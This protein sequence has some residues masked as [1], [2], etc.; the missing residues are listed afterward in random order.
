MS[1]PVQ[2]IITVNFTEH[3]WVASGI[4][5]SNEFDL[6]LESPFSLENYSTAIF[7]KLFNI[8]LSQIADLLDYH[9]LQLSAPVKWLNNLEKLIKLNAVHFTS[10]ELHHRHTKL[11][12]EIDHK[13]QSFQA[14][15]LG[16]HRRDLLLKN[17]NGFS[18]KKAYCFTAVKNQLTDLATHEE[19]IELLQD[20]IFEYRQDSPDFVSLKE[21]P[22]DVL[23]EL[24]IE[25]LEKKE[26][27][28]Q[29]AAQRKSR[30]SSA[31]VP[32]PKIKLNCNLNYFVD[33]FFLLSTKKTSS[34]VPYIDAT[35]MQI[36]NFLDQNF[37]D[38]NGD[39]ISQ[40]S[41]LTFLDPNRPDKRPKL[42]KSFR[43]G[44]DL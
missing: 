27:I 40:A 24:E 16:N 13:R 43:L 12:I 20:Q 41:I 37:L 42:N 35:P 29:K 7:R 26:L 44:D 14:S 19:K 39:K 33:I 23:C 3:I 5:Q 38:K 30:N 36:A 31:A 22:F 28:Q 25:K 1:D 9:C 11:M 10:P 21:K 2:N 18:D 4:G 8:R 6:V 15:S 17:V 34:G 32:V